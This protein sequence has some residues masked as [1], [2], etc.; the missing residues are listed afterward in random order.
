MG[1]SAGKVVEWSGVVL[2]LLVT[3]FISS[4][5]SAQPRA[6]TRE[7]LRLEG[8]P[9]QGGLVIGHTDPGSRVTLDERRIRVGRDGTFL[10]ALPMDA[11][12]TMALVVVRR[13][14][15][16]E[17]H[18][19]QIPQRQYATERL[20]A[21]PEGEV[22]LDRPT[23]VA[24]QKTRRRIETV[25]RRFT[26]EA[27]FQGGFETPAAGRVSTPFG[28]RR[29]LNGEPRGVHDAIDIAVPVGTTVRAPAGGIVVFTATDVP[30]SG[31]T[32]ILDHGMGLFST[33]I[34]MS[35][36]QVRQ[37]ERVER[38]ATL[39]RSGNTGRTTGPNLEWGVHLGTTALDPELLI[40]RAPAGHAA[41]PPTSPPGPAPAR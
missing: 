15:S 23:Q 8:N 39:G 40:A 4:V 38:G 2:A 11:P 1:R 26:P 6:P 21:L 17:E 28:V 14:G 5:A 32:V 19:F 41:A 22:E 24:L 12:Q 35:A 16:R 33:F 34:H 25:R 37:G 13:D 10:V 3:A 31:Q 20:D 27:M 29:V 36:I 7:A 30:L 9:A 18:T